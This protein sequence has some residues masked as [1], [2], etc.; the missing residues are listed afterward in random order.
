MFDSFVL[1]AI[2]VA[3]G[4][5]V[6]AV[7][8]LVYLFRSSGGDVRVNKEE[9]G[10]VVQRLGLFLILGVVPVVTA[11]TVCYLIIFT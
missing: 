11:V 10:A 1:Q 7:G 5:I 6:V 3:L 8:I 9:S 2:F 4:A